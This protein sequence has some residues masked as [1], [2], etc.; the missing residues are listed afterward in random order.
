MLHNCLLL[1]SLSKDFDKAPDVFKYD[2]FIFEDMRMLFE[3]KSMVEEQLISVLFKLYGSL[4]KNKVSSDSVNR[5][6]GYINAYYR[7]DI[8]ISELADILHLNR[9]SDLSVSLHG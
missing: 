6:I 5:A 4:F 8:K 9:N 1:I 3:E 7:N 2:D